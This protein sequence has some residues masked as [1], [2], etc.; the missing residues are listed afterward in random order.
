M[1]HKRKK[2][3]MKEDGIP[4]ETEVRLSIAECT[5]LREMAGNISP[6]H[7]VVELANN[8]YESTE[9]LSR[10]AQQVG[11]R[12]FNLALFGR[13]DSITRFDNTEFNS[14]I[15][16]SENTIDVTILSGSAYDLSRRWQE[17]VALLVVTGYQEYEKV[18]EAIICWQEYLSPEAFIV[19]HNCHEPGP[20]Q[21]IKEFH[22]D[23]GNF[24]I[25]NIIYNMTVLEIDKCRHY[26]V[27]NSSEI[28]ICRCCGRQRNF[29]KMM[30][31]VDAV[32]VRRRQAEKSPNKENKTKR[33][34]K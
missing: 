15:N 11:A 29:K 24:L 13:S 31:V 23:V 8:I 27:I 34:K 12:V 5:L 33:S 10:G 7:V 19:V 32:G 6:Q 3:V 14:G 21:A 16:E 18:R 2:E 9:A 26:W 4:A 25:Q 17:I 30:K 20:A 1:V 22:T 28:G